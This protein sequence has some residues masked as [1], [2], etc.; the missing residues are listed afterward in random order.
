MKLYPDRR[1]RF[2]AYAVVEGK[3]VPIGTFMFYA[4]AWEA[5]N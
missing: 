2:A 1:Y 5:L 4:D 3:V